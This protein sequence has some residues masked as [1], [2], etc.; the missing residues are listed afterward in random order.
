MP[1]EIAEEQITFSIRTRGRAAGSMLVTTMRPEG[2]REPIPGLLLLHEI[3]GVNP[4]VHATARALAKEGMA[5]FLPDLY[6]GRSG[7][8]TLARL[9]AGAA[10]WPLRNATLSDLRAALLEI[11]RLPEVDA[12]RLGVVGYSMGAAYALQLAC[13]EPSLR[14]AAVFCGQLPR[15]LQALR[16][17]CPIVASYAGR[18][19]TCRGMAPRLGRALMEYDISYDLKVYTSVSHAFY[20]P[21][22]RMYDPH[23]A[24]DAWDRTIN[25]VRAHVRG[26]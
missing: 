17:T 1:V 10:L 2:M 5:V 14:V 7:F 18:D 6:A 20:D 24:S 21:F 16:R 4:S 9:V 26:G 25:F 19:V 23:A 12:S 8:T 15:P 13:T 22:G 11:G 3:G